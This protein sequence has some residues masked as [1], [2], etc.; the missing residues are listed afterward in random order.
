MFSY[1]VQYRNG[2]ICIYRGLSVLLMYVFTTCYV[3]VSRVTNRNTAP[4]E[5]VNDEDEMRRSDAAASRSAWLVNSIRGVCAEG[6]GMQTTGEKV[7]E[8]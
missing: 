8:W 7:Q 2:C 6:R 3:Y 4:E 5:P 1:S